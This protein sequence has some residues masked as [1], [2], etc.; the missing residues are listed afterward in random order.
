MTTFTKNIALCALITASPMAFAETP[1][2][3]LLQ[4]TVV[5]EEEA[6]QEKTMVK[7]HSI[8]KYEENAKCNTHNGKRLEFKLPHD[9][10]VNAAPSGSE[11]KYRYK[12]DEAGQTESELIMIGA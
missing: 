12:T 6:G 5:H 2:D 9:S 10:R 11:V 7:I 1:K 4:G 3:C 8:T